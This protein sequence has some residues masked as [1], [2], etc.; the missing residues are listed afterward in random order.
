M[1]NTGMAMPSHKV[2]VESLEKLLSEILLGEKD[3]R[4][5]F[6]SLPAESKEKLK[7]VLKTPKQNTFGIATN[8]E[9]ILNL[10][11]V[12]KGSLV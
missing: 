6:D 1:E 2:M 9:S 10:V 12:R 11:S 3:E 5:M 8:D 4:N 7:G